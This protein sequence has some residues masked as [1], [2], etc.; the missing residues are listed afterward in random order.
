MSKYTK[1]VDGGYEF[2]S[3]SASGKELIPEGVALTAVEASS[4]IGAPART[5]MKPPVNV[6]RD[7][8]GIFPA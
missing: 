7:A 4:A 8:L 6:K 2:G 5:R 3:V 1:K